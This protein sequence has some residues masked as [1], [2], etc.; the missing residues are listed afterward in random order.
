[1]YYAHGFNSA[2]TKMPAL[3]TGSQAFGSPGIPPR[4]TSARKEAIGTAYS[5]ASRVWFT[6]WEGILTEI[7]YPTVDHPQT[8]DWQLL[9][10]D[11][12]SLFHEEKRDFKTL[13][14]P[15]T[16]E[17]LGFKVVQTQE[18]MGYSFEKTVITDPHH[19]C[20]LQHVKLNVPEDLR[21]RLDVYTLCSPHLGVGGADNNAY[22]C[23]VNGQKVLVAN[24]KNT[25]LAIG[26]S[27]PF[28]KASCGYAGASDGWTDLNGNCKMDWEFDCALE[29]NVALTGLLDLQGRDE[30]V[31]AMAFGHGYHNAVAL[32]LQS[33]AFP[34]STHLNRFCEQWQRAD[35][36]EKRLY[37]FAHDQG[38]LYDASY[39]T[40]IAHEDKSNPGAFIASLSIPWGETKGDDDLGG[41]HLVWPR[42]MVNTAT[43]LLAAGNEDMPLRAL[44]F[45]AAAQKADGGFYQNFWISGEPYWTGVQLD[46]VSFPI[47]LAWRLKRHGALK[48]FNPYNM[49]A[50]A[51]AF[52]ILN[53]PITQQERW[54]EVA[55]FSPSTLASNIAAIT[56]ASSF[57]RA[58]GDDL[59]ADLIQD[60]ADYLRC[61]LEDWTVTTSG[62]LLPGVPEHFVRINPVRDVHN[63]TSPNDAQVFV[64]NRTPWQ[65][66]VF[67]ARNIVD[68]GFLELVRYGIYPADSKLIEDSLAVVDAVL[69]VDTPKGPC[70]HRYNYDGYGQKTDGS[71]YDGSGVGRAWPLLTG[72]RGHYELAAGKDVTPYLKTLENFVSR[73]GTLPEQVWDTDDIPEAHLYKGGTTGA[74]RPLAWAHAEYIK[75]LRSAADGKIFDLIPEVEDRYIKSPQLCKLIEIWHHKWQTPAVRVNYSLRILA[76]EPFELALSFDDWQTTETIPCTSTKIGVHYC[77][78]AVGADSGAEISFTFHWLE[79]E[80][81]EGT[82]YFVEIQQ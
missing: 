80:S 43:G 9:L 50:S 79:P 46:E 21:P 54:E 33:L 65:Q 44:M 7:Y 5:A 40:L 68:A 75:L 27:V 73:G 4:W 24:K 78:V 1:V 74:A 29:G 63:M 8:R 35:K 22:I 70:W 49:V 55:G 57:A 16:R 58:A 34:F 17:S 31:L 41:Y 53:G 51:V 23:S 72:E 32:L 67:E 12:E 52:L 47:M 66:Q 13:V 18:E 6:L 59:S 82:N 15:I 39:K 76:A 77:D 38:H 61:H 81:W 3:L 10:S 14:A 71:A 28:S 37:S 26:A 36:K 62:D 30:F 45:L 48:E 56:C 11:G 20:V 42:D 64:A 60:Y 2:I 19:P 25:W 69:K